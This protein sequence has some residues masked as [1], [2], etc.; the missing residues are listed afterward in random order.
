MVMIYTHANDQGQ[1]SVGLKDREKTSGRGLA[2]ERTEPI[3]L[4]SVLMRSLKYECRDYLKMLSKGSFTS[5]KLKST[6]RNKFRAANSSLVQFSS[7]NV[8]GP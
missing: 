5:Q 8:N 6:D 3:A 2:D 4:P 7:C 1:M